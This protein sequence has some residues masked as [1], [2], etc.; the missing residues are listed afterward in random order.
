MVFNI[1]QHRCAR[2]HSLTPLLSWVCAPLLS[3]AAASHA[4]EILSVW[5]PPS[6]PV[7]LVSF[8]GAFSWTAHDPG[9]CR[10]SVY[11]QAGV[12][13]WSPALSSLPPMS[14]KHKYLWRACYPA[15]SPSHLPA[16]PSLLAQGGPSVPPLHHG[17]KG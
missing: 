6:Q 15:C 13:R 1:V 17:P 8:P 12:N 16:F 7:A 5:T 4:G 3:P 9:P 11:L 2:G 10:T 14:P